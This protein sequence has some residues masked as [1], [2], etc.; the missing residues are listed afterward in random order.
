[1]SPALACVPPGETM[2]SQELFPAEITMQAAYEKLLINKLGATSEIK[3]SCSSMLLH[4][5]VSYI[6]NLI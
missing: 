5:E 6:N 4:K 1:M 2:I 3:K